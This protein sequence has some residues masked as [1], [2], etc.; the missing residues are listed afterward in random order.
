MFQ[1]PSFL[2]TLKPESV[3]GCQKPCS[4]TKPL[5]KVFASPEAAAI[6]GVAGNWPDGRT[7]D[8]LDFLPTEGCPD[9]NRHLP[10]APSRPIRAKGAGRAPTRSGGLALWWGCAPRMGRGGV[11]LV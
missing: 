3:S 9:L 1:K 5:L 4:K 10:Q 6:R 7:V 8:L 2:E 11:W